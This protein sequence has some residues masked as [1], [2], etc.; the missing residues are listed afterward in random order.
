VI[1]VDTN[2]LVYAHVTAF[3]QHAAAKDW[4]DGRFS[5]SSRVGLAWPSLLGFVRLVTNPRVFE[6]PE[7]IPQAWQ[8]AEAWLDSPVSWVPLP[9]DRHREVLSEL[10][11]TPDLRANHVPDAHL[12]AIAIE[13]GLTLCSTDSDFA[14]FAGL[15]W[16]NPLG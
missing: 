8:Q 16:K 14:R 13:H 15:R 5:G 12:A 9:T 1:L 7:T 4:L 2:L 10:L 6:R 3:P 11:A